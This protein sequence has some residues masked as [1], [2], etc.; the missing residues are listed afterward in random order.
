[1]VR[2]DVNFTGMRKT[3]SALG[4][5]NKKAERAV[6]RSVHRSAQYLR[7][8][9]VQGIRSQAP[10]G[11]RFKPLK[12][13]TVARKKSSKA[14]INHGDLIR[15]VNVTRV[16]S[17]R[18]I[19][20]FVGVHRNAVGKD[21]QSLAN[22]AEIHEDGSKKVKDRPPARPFLQP[23]WDVWVRTAE[24]QFARDVAGELGLEGS[25]GERVVATA[26]GGS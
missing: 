8:Q 20:F 19:V 15:S 3:L 13:E 18:Q 9:I 25:L 23:S 21:G 5:W 7:R 12:P 26:T 6:E 22:I 16:A 2:V 10:G 11:K 4:Q 17:G 14:L 1:M 24:Q